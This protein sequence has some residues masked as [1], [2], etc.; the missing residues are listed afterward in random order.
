MTVLSELPATPVY[1]RINVRG[2]I[3]ALCSQMTVKENTLTLR[4]TWCKLL[5]KIT[6]AGFNSVLS[7]EMACPQE[8]II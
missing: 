8:N 5:C 7:L 2:Y 1:T 6:R 3:I 4:G